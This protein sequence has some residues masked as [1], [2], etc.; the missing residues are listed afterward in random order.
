MD[1]EFRMEWVCMHSEMD[2]ECP[3]SRVLCAFSNEICVHSDMN[4]EVDSD[5][6][7]VYVTVCILTWLLNA[8]WT[9]G[10]LQH[11]S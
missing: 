7:S 5:T 3:V 9:L 10:A 6:H 1:S 2:V 8:T 4:S 11:G